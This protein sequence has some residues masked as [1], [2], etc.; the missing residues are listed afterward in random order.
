MDVRVANIRRVDEE[1]EF[2]VVGL[3]ELLVHLGLLFTLLA[4][5]ESRISA[6]SWLKRRVRT[7]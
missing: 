4:V 5:A 2:I 6:C 3:A 1:V 7:C